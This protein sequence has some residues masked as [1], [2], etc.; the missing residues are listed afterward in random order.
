MHLSDFPFVKHL[1]IHQDDCIKAVRKGGNSVCLTSRYRS[2]VV[3][4]AYGKPV[5]SGFVFPYILKILSILFRVLFAESR[6]IYPDALRLC[7]VRAGCKGDGCHCKNYISEN[8]HFFSFSIGIFKSL[9]FPFAI[10]L[11]ATLIF[12]G[13]PYIGT[14][15]VRASEH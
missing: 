12:L 14:H 9:T 4:P 5:V 7:P 3:K 6:R 2:T 10:S 13:P 11:Q 1:R 8:F 15:V